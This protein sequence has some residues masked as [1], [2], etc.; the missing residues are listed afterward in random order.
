MAL[1]QQ[2]LR[3][4]ERKVKQKPRLSRPEKRMRVALRT[5]LQRQTRHWQQRARQAVVLIQPETVLKG[6]RE[7]V[8]PKW[9]FRQPDRGGGPKLEGEIEA[10]ILRSARENPRMGYAKIPGERLKLGFTVDPTTVQQVLRRHRLLPTPPRGRRWWRT[11][12]NPD[13]PQ[14]RA[15]DGFT[16]ETLCLPTR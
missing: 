9:T 5:G 14:M 3:V 8:R 13:R 4:L 1:L 10:L 12:L 11:F 15:C 16:V 2:Q 6:Q 7:L